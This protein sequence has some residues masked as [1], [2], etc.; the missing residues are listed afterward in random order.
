MK[1]I[2]GQLAQFEVKVVNQPRYLVKRLITILFLPQ[3]L[4]REKIQKSNSTL[5]KTVCLNYSIIYFFCYFIYFS[6]LLFI[7]FGSVTFSVG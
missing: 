1:H 4:P 6:L 7:F 5:Y 3:S 2:T